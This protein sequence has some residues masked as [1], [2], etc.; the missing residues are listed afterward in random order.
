MNSSLADIEVLLLSENRQGRQIP[1]S[2]GPAWQRGQGEDA[3]KGGQ[4]DGLGRHHRVPAVGLGQHPG[5][6][7]GGGGLRM[8]QAQKWMGST[9]GEENQQDDGGGGRQLVEGGAVEDGR[10]KVLFRSARPFGPPHHHGQG[11]V[12]VGDIADGLAHRAGERQPVRNRNSP[13]A[14]P[15]CRG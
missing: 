2:V 4:G 6:A 13:T 15:R 7:G 1:V 3:Q 10:V 8:T 5:H 14:S 9:S 12:Q 11:G